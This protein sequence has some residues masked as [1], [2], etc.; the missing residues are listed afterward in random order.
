MQARLPSMKNDAFFL[1]LLLLLLPACTSPG[2]QPASATPASPA[3]PPLLQQA[4]QAHGGLERWQSFETLRFSWESGDKGPVRSSVVDLKTRRERIRSEEYEMGFDGQNYWYLLPEGSQAKPNPRFAI[5]LEF[6][7]FGM[8]FVAADPGIKYEYLGQKVAH[9]TPYEA[10]KITFDDGTGV[11]PKDQYILHFDPK[12]H[13][14]A[15]LLYSVTYFDSSRATTYN[16]RV[17]DDWQQINGLWVPRQATSY[18]WN[19]QTDSLGAQRAT[20]I[21]K[22]VSFDSQPPADSLFAMPDGAVLAT[23]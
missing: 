9:G 15:L 4:L 13:R 8:P 3:Y 1:G 18:R 17:Y 16:A 2:S 11:A 12:T 21:Y 19:A 6:Y 23:Q 7:F 22:Q 10:L 20:H 5:N 14:L